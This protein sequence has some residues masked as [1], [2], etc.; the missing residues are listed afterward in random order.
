MFGL[1]DFIDLLV[2]RL[3][4]T[5]LLD[6]D[7]IYGTLPPVVEG[8]WLPF[9]YPPFAA[10]L[11]APLALI[12]VELGKLVFTLVSVAALA[13]TLRVVLARVWPQLEARAAWAATAIAVA[14]ALLLEPVRETISFGQI[15]MILMALVAIDVLARNPKWPRGVLIGVAAAIK[16]TPIGFLLLFL[17]KRDWRTSAHIVGGA[18]GSSALAFVVIP[19][20]SVKYWLHTLAD[21][22]R[23]G[24]E[25]FANNLSFKAVISRFGPTE[26]LGSGLWVVAVAVMLVVAVMAI[27]RALD[28]D[29]IVM[30]MT[31]NA[32]AILLASPVSWS[33]HWV[34]VAPALLA[35]VA[36]VLRAPDTRTVAGAI[37]LGVVFLIGPHHL[38]PAGDDLE[39]DWALW[40]HLLGT[41]Y[42]TVGLGFLV[43]L[44]FASYRVRPQ[45]APP[46]A[47]SNIGG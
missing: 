29:D 20:T 23:I 10:M 42:V 26:Q 12:P 2:Y 38:L 28:H 43:W 11:F 21:T 45:S 9:T 36:V 40:Q 47:F 1:G 14:V 32:V 19:D 30:A 31:A 39:L 44:A 3:G 18:L 46:K 15:N 17:V 16:L 41:L 34:W 6:G 24:A 33:H 13:V 5:V 22:G 4:A 37:G 7:D 35:L 27:R 8:V 25:Y